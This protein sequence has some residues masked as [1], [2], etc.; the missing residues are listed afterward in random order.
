MT[1]FLSTY[2]KNCGVFLALQFQ[3]DLFGWL[4]VKLVFANFK[5]PIC[6]ITNAKKSAFCLNTRPRAKDELKWKPLKRKK[7]KNGKCYRHFFS[8]SLRSNI[9]NGYAPKMVVQLLL[10]TKMNRKIPCVINC[11]PPSSRSPLYH[12]PLF[13][14]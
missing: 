12:F 10:W 14:V 3:F 11:L 4:K 1:Q 13:F 6:S 8:H 9:F 5:L 2:F 7:K